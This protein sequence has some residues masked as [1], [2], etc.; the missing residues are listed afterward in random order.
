MTLRAALYLRVS[1]ARQAEQDLSI[2]DQRRQAEA[3]CRRQGWSVTAEYEEPG[4]SATD[5]KRPEFQRMIEHAKKSPRPFDVVVVHSFSRFFR[6]AFQSELY[7]R[8]LRKFGVALRSITQEI[9]DDPSGN[10]VRQI[11]AMFDEHSSRENAKHTLRG[12]QENA[13]Q[14][15]WNGSAPPFG[16]RTYEAERRGEK[17]KKRLEIE[18]REA[19]LV[20]Q[21]FALYLDGE[22]G[23]PLGII[24]IAHRLNRSGVRYRQGREFSA[25]LIHKILTRTAYKGDHYFN[26]TDSKTF[27]RKP[28][29]AWIH[30]SVP[31]ILDEARFEAAQHKLRESNPRVTP[32]RVVNGPTLLTGILHC[33]GCG[34]GMTLRTGKSGRYRYYACSAAMRM[35]KTKCTGRSV[36]MDRLDKLVVDHLS[37]KL[38][39]PD[40]LKVLLSDQIARAKRSRT[41]SE[42]KTKA[43]RTEIKEIERA[44]SRLYE[45]IE[46][47]ITSLD[48]EALRKR[49]GD[50][51]ARREECLRLIAVASHRAGAPAAVL[52]SAS[53]EAFGRAIRERLASPNVAFRKAYIRLY[54]GRIEL[55]ETEV[56]MFG[57]KDRLL[58]G[59]ENPPNG[60][61][62]S[63]PSFIRAWRPREE[64]NLRP[65]V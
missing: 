51:K 39:A 34:G 53:I 10:M 43:L 42:D 27:E 15:F 35:G 58:E 55:D 21:I 52:S 54:V 31:A 61:K 18:P 56:R 33:A 12:M 46:R 59:I 30:F 22:A 41:T 17:I 60:E 44:Q 3:F 49:L 20:R 38:F 45:A 19:E 48:D 4:A 14:G 24:A 36:P 47:G 63:V 62:P 28:E 26:R 16:Y 6:D 5:D 25:G 13:R 8:T 23:S 2:P 11:V 64:S 29:S 9:G 37:E 40:R 50:L 65:T 1:T 32:P 57:P 7:I